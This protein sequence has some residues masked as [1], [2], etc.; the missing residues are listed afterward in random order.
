VLEHSEALTRPVI[1][2]SAAL[3]AAFAASG[4]KREIAIDFAA[5]ARRGGRLNHPDGLW[6]GS[7]LCFVII[8]ILS[9]E[10]DGVVCFGESPFI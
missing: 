9:W 4:D 8:R 3:L 1:L 6:R 5:L 7:E 10:L 2:V